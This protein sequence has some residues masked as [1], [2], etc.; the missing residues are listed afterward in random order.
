MIC[1]ERQSITAVIDKLNYAGERDSH[2]L[3]QAIKTIKGRLP[4]CGSSAREIPADC[5]CHS[6]DDPQP[7]LIGADIEG[8]LDNNEWEEA[9]QLLFEWLLSDNCPSNDI[10]DVLNDSL[11][12]LRSRLALEP[13][14]RLM[15]KMVYQEG[16]KLNIVAKAF[17]MPSYQPGR[18]LKSIHQRIQ[19][20]LSEAN[21]NLSSL[22]FNG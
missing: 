10:G 16:L 20:A 8:Q 3:Q 21:I 7:E 14:E 19:T 1:L 12:Q 17:N 22:D 9:L 4:W 5:L 18:L 13:Q 6:E 2:Y 15:L 11:D